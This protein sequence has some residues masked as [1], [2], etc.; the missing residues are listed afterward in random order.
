MTSAATLVLAVLVALVLT[1]AVRRVPGLVAIPLPSRW[2]QAATPTT[3]GIA[4]FGAFLLALQPALLLGAVDRRYIPLILGAGA[5]F[6]LGLWDDGRPL[7]PSR[8]LAAQVAIAVGASAAGVRP[9]WLP[10]GAAVIVGAVVL[11]ACMNSVNLLDNMDGLAAGTTAI[12]ALALAVI[13]GSMPAAGSTVVAAALA[14][15]CIGFL[16]QNYRRN[17]PAAV[18]MGD[19]GSHLL[20]FCLGGLAVLASPGGVG[21]VAAAVAAPLLVLAV[22]MLDTVLVMAVRFSEGRPIWEGG[23]DHSSHRLV[24]SGRTQHQAV[25]VLF[26]VTA[27]CSGTA[28]VLAVVKEPILTATACG[29]AFAS[30]VAFGT[31]L[32]T[33]TEENPGRVLPFRGRRSEQAEDRQSGVS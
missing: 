16:P 20:G 3:G 13:A 18:F 14:G 31:R 23:R 15:A 21:G 10:L 12:A 24:Y 9:D 19:S 29:L 4:L 5:A 2:S 30:L 11:I 33:V 7:G 27:L 8:K 25:A 17:K 1:P 6:A 32:S 26:G 28:V 22:P